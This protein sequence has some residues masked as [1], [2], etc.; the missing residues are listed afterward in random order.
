MFATR[1]SAALRSARTGGYAV[2]ACNVVDATTMDAVLAAAEQ[3]SSPVVVQVS[4]RTAIAWSPPRIAA[5]FRAL[6]GE[7]DVAATLHLD[8]CT[9]S[10]LVLSCMAVGWNSALF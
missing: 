4:T 3:Y 2:P 5:I 7:R 10:A 9:D 1:L 6:A 8:H